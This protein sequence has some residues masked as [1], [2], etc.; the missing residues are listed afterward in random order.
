MTKKRVKIGG[1]SL[2][3][4]LR[5]LPLS[6]RK[7]LTFDIKVSQLVSTQKSPLIHLLEERKKSKGY[8]C[9][10]FHKKW[11]SSLGDTG[12]KAPKVVTF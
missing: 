1:S 11:I 3:K 10:Q 9:A 8:D 4:C 6:N 12:K 2:R 5:P 7:C